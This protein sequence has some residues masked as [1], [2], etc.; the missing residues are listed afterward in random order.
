MRKSNIYFV[1]A[2]MCALTA[3]T[4]LYNGFIP[5]AVIMYGVFIFCVVRLILIKNAM[6]QRLIEE[7]EK[8]R[9]RMSA[10]Y[11]YIEENR[12]M[13][14]DEIEQAVKDKPA[15]GVRPGSRPSTKYLEMKAGESL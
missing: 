11:S 6:D 12:M 14:A 3:D 2:L 10:L 13:T 9:R 8:T 7:C 5:V 4:A 15:G 1:T